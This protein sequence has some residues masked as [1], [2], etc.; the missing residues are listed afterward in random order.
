MLIVLLWPTLMLLY[1]VIVR[2]YKVRLIPGCLGA[3]FFGIASLWAILEI[4]H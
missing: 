1:I 2:S 3:I 4:L